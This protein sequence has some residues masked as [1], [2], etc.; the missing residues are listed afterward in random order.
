MSARF[1]IVLAS[2]VAVMPAHAWWDGGHKMIA[3]I[4]HAQLS[5]EER[6][7]V[8]RLLDEHP[9]RAE[10]FDAPMRAELGDQPGEEQR[11]LWFFAQASIWSDLIRNRDGYPNAGDIN[12]TYHHSSWHYTDI[13]VF[14]DDAARAALSGKVAMPQLDW[15]PGMA[16]PE[17]GFNSVQT[18]NRAVHELSDPNV[19]V[20]QR[21]VDLCWLFHLM[22]DFHQPCHC[23]ELYVPEKLPEG[24]RGANRLLILGISRANPALQ[25]DVLHFF[26]DSIWNGE[27]N[28][29]KAV[30]TRL[31]PLMQDE[32]LLAL[33]RGKASV[34]DAVSLLKEGHSLASQHVYSPMLM[35]RI[36]L[37]QPVP[38][39]GPGRKQN[40]LL[41]TLPA[42]A[43]EA[44]IDEARQIARLQIVV[45]GMRLAALLKQIH[46]GLP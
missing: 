37:L 24:D 11:S 43:S 7:W 46:A 23:A 36:Q 10:L 16:E 19:P 18:L 42:A 3:L 38:N 28:D 25:S 45:A 29:L 15:T 27:T 17:Q 32:P 4:A 6:S 39:P 35:S 20:S 40:V 22:G 9:T 44:Y 26:W 8:M 2:F 21:A 13:P 14:P 5:P 31:M 30:Q 12:R 34:I 41:V 1:F 33:A